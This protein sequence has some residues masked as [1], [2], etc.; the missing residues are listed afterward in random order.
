MGVEA[1]EIAH[2]ADVA[3]L[4]MENVVMMCKMRYPTLFG[5]LTTRGALTLR[6]L[7]PEIGSV[8]FLCE[9]YAPDQALEGYYD[10]SSS[11]SNDESSDSDE[12]FS[13]LSS[14]S[15]WEE[16]SS[17]SARKRRREEAC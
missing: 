1:R 14:S 16:E 15:S 10:S 6:D 11:Y 2:R 12:A 3:L 8:I 5:R 13:L 17:C 9:P 7:L 4:T